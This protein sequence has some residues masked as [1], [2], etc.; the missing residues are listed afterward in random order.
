MYSQTHTR[1]IAGP[2]RASGKLVDE[3]VF[4][5]GSGRTAD[6]D[7]VS[8]SMIR[9]P[10]GLAFRATG[11]RLPQPVEDSDIERL[12]QSVATRLN[13]FE[14]ARL[15]LQ[16]EDWI[17]VC[18]NWYGDADRDNGERKTS[19]AIDTRMLKR[20]VNPDTGEALT[21]NFNGIIVPFPKAKAAGEQEE[22]AVS[23]TGFRIG[24]HRNRDSSYAYIPATAGNLLAIQDIHDRLRDLRG[25]MTDLLDQDRIDHS[26]AS[27]VA[28]L[29][30]APED[31]EKPRTGP[32]H[33]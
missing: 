17:E 8:V 16:W 4:H 28:G 31:T 33:G 21:I 22:A 13:E 3:W 20:A 29:L 14:D 2:S 5:A 18:V 27:L 11:D 24:G 7:K 1:L 15:G 19:L 9:T 6:A 12:R 32:R 23:A 10:S 30:P 26:M 25:R